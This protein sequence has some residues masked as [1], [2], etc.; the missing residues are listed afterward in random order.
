MAHTDYRLTNRDEWEFTYTGAELLG[1][2]RRKHTE[3]TVKEREARR[4]MADMMMDMAVAQSDPRIS[5][6]KKDIEKFGSERERCTVWIHEFIRVPDQ[7]YVLQVGDVAYF[8][9][10]P[11][12]EDS[13]LRRA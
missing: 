6:C 1:A 4:K 8:D 10:A 7:T 9:L 13:T 5:E 2:A 12:P 3:F 11:E